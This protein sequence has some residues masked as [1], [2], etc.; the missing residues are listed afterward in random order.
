M[1]AFLGRLGSFNPVLIDGYAES[2]NF[3]AAQSWARRA[4]TD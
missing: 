1:A 3:L 4:S 2:F